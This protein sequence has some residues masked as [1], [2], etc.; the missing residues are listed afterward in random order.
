MILYP[1]IDLKDGQAVRLLRG[2]MEQATVFNDDPAAQA[3]AFVEAGC[4]W[5]HLVDLNGAFAG[6]PVNA[7]PVEAI[8]DRCDVPAQ[9]GGGIRDMETI[10]SWLTKGLARVILGTVAVEDPDLVRDAARAFPG[11]VAVGI[12][13]RGGRV[14]TRG[15]AEETDVEVTDLARSFEDAGV[16]AIIY[17]DINRDGAMQGPNIPATEALAR[18]VSIPVIASGGVSALDDLIALRDTSVVAGAI[19]GRALYDGA[20]D[21]KAALSALKG[22]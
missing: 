21:L 17:T 6:E 4:E 1:A 5:L 11:Q 9:L 20:L 13:A 19:S 7:A 2:E 14:A 22:S 18:A 8:L 16:A 3:A 10:E 15:W 12:D